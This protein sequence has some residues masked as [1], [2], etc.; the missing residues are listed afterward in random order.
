MLKRLID[1]LLEM[2]QER[3]I[4]IDNGSNYDPLLNYYQEIGNS[5]EI[6]RMEKNHGYKVFTNLCRDPQ[7]FTRY[8]LDQEN[9]MYTD[10]DIVPCEECLPDFVDK[11]NDILGRYPD[12]KKVGFGLKIDDLPDSFEA[13][14]RLIRW[15]SQFWIDKIHDDET[16][17]DLYPAA[18]DTGFAMRRANT[19]PGWTNLSFRTGFPYVAR[20]LP[21]YI[22]NNNLSEENQN[23][24]RTASEFDTHFPGRYYKEHST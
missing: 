4:I 5:F 23:Y 20:H 2:G 8:K 19:I 10:C 11:W 15:E 24:I 22:D 17:I 7:F 18:I 6:L 16:G 1:R 21:W 12:I 3:I 13:K 14:E 9:F